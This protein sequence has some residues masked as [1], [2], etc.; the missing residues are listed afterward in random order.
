VNLFYVM[1]GGMGHLFRIAVFIKQ[2]AIEDYVILSANALAFKLF[3]E[4]KITFI[5]PEN[6][7]EAWKS[8]VNEKLPTLHVEK[9]FIDSFPFGLAAEFSCWPT[10]NY[11]VYY[12]ARRLKWHN[13]KSTLEQIKF[14]FE[15]VYQLEELEDEHLNFLSSKTKNIE[16]LT[17]NYPQPEE[18]NL[19]AFKI[20]SDK[21]LWLIVH[22]FNTDELEMLVQY[23]KEAAYQEQ[24]NPYFVVISDQEIKISNGVCMRYFPAADWFPLAA[25]IFCGAGFNTVQQVK[26]FLSKTTLIPF[27]RKYDDQAWRAGVLSRS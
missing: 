21:V 22:A 2:F 12:L 27:P 9:L 17:L 13:Y 3:P 19:S 4:S 8:F 6:Y 14:D 5:S 25:R 26:P 18:I 11:P 1:G 20:P 24:C 10:V 16:Q 7:E 23:A 15:T